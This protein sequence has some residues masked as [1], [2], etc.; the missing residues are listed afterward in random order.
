MDFKGAL[1]KLAGRLGFTAYTN[2]SPTDGEVWYEGGRLKGREA[3][4]TYN[5]TDLGSAPFPDATQT[6]YVGKN[7]DDGD[8]GLSPDMPK[9]TIASALTVASGLTP[10]ATNRIAVVILDG[11]TYTEN[12]TVPA[13]CNLIGHGATVVGTI[14]LG[15]DT[16]VR[17]YE[18]KANTSQ[19]NPILYKASGTST[20]YAD[21]DRIDGRNGGSLICVQNT[22]NGSVMFIKAKQIWVGAGQKGVG[23]TAGGFGHIHLYAMDVYCAGTNAVAIS[24]NNNNSSIVGF[25]D[26]I[27]ETD[28]P[29]GT[30]GVL[31]GASGIVSLHVGEIITD[32]AYDITTG[33]QL[34]LSCPRL[35]GT[36]VG[37]PT[38]LS[39]QSGIISGGF[40]TVDGDIETGAGY[41][42][43]DG[44]FITNLDASA[45]ATNS[46]PANRISATNVT[47]ANAS[48][49]LSSTDQGKVIIMTNANPTVTIPDTLSAGFNCLVVYGGTGGTLTLSGSGSMTLRYPSVQAG[50]IS[51]TYGT[52]SVIVYAT[53]NALV[54]GFLDAA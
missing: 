26:H 19:T 36:L 4:V 51:D 37:T 20:T 42:I 12:I 9:L 35:V 50:T 29:T 30:V 32:T 25:I 7:G 18:A 13:F 34:S 1:F 38:Y 22:A 6:V 47:D 53:N 44:K 16:A 28:A 21:I 40:Y 33:G 14:T 2:A 41:F 3:G 11:G 49:T 43:G 10:S 52:V 8:D 5:L 31:V 45:L 48:R 39:S 23:D 27:L 24:S 15:D 17:L 54:T 46:V